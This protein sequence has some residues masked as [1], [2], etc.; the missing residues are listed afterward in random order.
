MAQQSGSNGYS[1]VVIQLQ[2]EEILPFTVSASTALLQH[3][4]K[5]MADTGWLY[6]FND[7]ESL[8]IRADKIVAINFKSLTKE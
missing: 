4:I 7:S 3:C 8:A 5:Q 6:L 2:G 1:L